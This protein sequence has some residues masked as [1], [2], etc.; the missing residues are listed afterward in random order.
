[1]IPCYALG[2]GQIF[3]HALG[4]YK[5]PEFKLRVTF[6]ERSDMKPAPTTLKNLRNP[7]ALDFCRPRKYFCSFQRAEKRLDGQPN[8]NT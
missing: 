5:T 3:E 7:R 8:Q 2:L 4:Y 1:M 6:T